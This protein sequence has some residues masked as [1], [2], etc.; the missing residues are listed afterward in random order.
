M[1]GGWKCIGS[2][3]ENGS[4]LYIP[5][6]RRLINCICLYTEYDDPIFIRNMYNQFTTHS[7]R[8]TLGNTRLL[9]C[10]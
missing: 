1:H 3:L 9:M 5:Y 7:V 8:N 4:E 10:C 6:N 2:R